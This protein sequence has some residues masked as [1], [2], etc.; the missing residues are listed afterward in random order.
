M[1]WKQ[2]SASRDPG[3]KVRIFAPGSRHAHFSN[4]APYRGWGKMAVE[5]TKSTTHQPGVTPVEVARV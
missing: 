4:P 3:A 2:K 1:I 5:M